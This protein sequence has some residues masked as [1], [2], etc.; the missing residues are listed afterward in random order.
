MNG[1]Q[2][3][4]LQ[5]RKKKKVCISSL[6][7]N[8]QILTKIKILRDSKQNVKLHNLVHCHLRTWCA[9]FNSGL[10]I[11]T[12][13]NIFYPLFRMLLLFLG[14][15]FSSFGGLCFLSR[16]SLGCRGVGACQYWWA[17]RALYTG[18]AEVSC[19]SVTTKSQLDMESHA[20]SKHKSQF[21]QF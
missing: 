10:H 12:T 17:L 5:K 7:K 2:E 11:L 6:W 14:A 15:F 21:D 9:P 19:T 18:D 20:F 4:R 13:F 1:F 16:C 8:T 3:S